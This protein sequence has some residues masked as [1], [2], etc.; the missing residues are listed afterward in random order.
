MIFFAVVRSIFITVLIC[1]IGSSF[2]GSCDG[3]QSARSAS[4]PALVRF[5]EFDSVPSRSPKSFC[6]SSSQ[7]NNCPHHFCSAVS[8]FFPGKTCAFSVS[9]P[10]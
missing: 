10:N 3:L 7:S 5:S 4:L 6:P 1:L 9:V 8:L 2:T